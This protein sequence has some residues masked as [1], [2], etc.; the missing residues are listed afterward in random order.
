MPSY[1]HPQPP[2]PAPTQAEPLGQILCREG[3]LAAADLDAALQRQS[4]LNVRLGEVLL[5]SGQISQQG[6]ETALARQDGAAPVDLAQDPPDPALLAQIDPQTC[7]RDG[8]LP[9]RREAGRTVVV[10]ESRIVPAD[11]PAEWANLP[12]LCL[13]RAKLGTLHPAISEAFGASLLARAHQLCPPAQ[14]CRTIAPGLR[15]FVSAGALLAIAG[16]ALAPITTIALALCWFVLMNAA[17]S[18]L[19]LGAL[20]AHLPR[21]GETEHAVPVLAP[22]RAR[23]KV[24]VLV[25]LLAEDA[26]LASLFERIAEFDYPHEL[27]DV[28]ILTEAD[29]AITANALARRDLPPWIRVLRLP[30][31]GLRT[32]PKAMNYALPFCHGSIIGIYDAEDRPEPDQISKVVAHLQNAPPDVACVQGYLDFYNSRANWLSRCFTIEYAVWFRVL[33]KGVQRLGLPIPLGGTTVFFRRNLLEEV[34]GWDAHNVTEDADL[35]FRLAGHGYRCEIVET[36]TWEEANCLPYSWIKQRARWLKGY[37]MTW[38]SHMRNPRQLLHEMGLR[39]FLAFQVL[40]LGTLTAYL[41]MPL[42]WGMW[43][44]WIGGWHSLL[45]VLPEP[46]V[47]VFFITSILGQSVMLAVAYLALRAPARRGLLPFVLTM[48]FYWPLGA[49]AAFRAVGQL[50]TAPFY[51]AKTTHGLRAGETE[52]DRAERP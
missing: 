5:A 8:W 13:R 52:T 19:R 31:D 36:T 37:A 15:H 30:D 4:G 47:I 51:W 2:P 1:L 20:F 40:V 34:G 18:L 3:L 33:L 9:W 11:L 17:T 39:N 49:L 23:P 38:A 27:L 29:D 50:I 7:L 44:S 42:V 12:G 48:P 6:L 35:G 22:R 26:V 41:S 16:L 10:S 24:S 25:P 46:V 45:S 21:R 43:A 32:K 14:S 28:I